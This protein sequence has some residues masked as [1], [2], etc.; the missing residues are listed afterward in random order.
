MW[1]TGTVSRMRDL[2]SAF[3]SLFLPLVAAAVLVR[4]T[5]LFS[6]AAAQVAMLLG[7]MSMLYG[8][9]NALRHHRVGG[10]L[11]SITA[12]QSGTL[13]LN[14]VLLPTQG[15]AWLFY[16]LGCYGLNLACLW[17]GAVNARQE[18]GAP[19][20]VNAIQGLGRRRPW[21]A[22]VLTL[23]LLDVAG[24][25]PLAGGI[26]QLHVLGSILQGG[27]P[28]VLLALAIGANA[29]AWLLV[30]RWILAMWVS[31]T[32]ARQLMPTT[33]EAAVV[34]VAAVGGMLIAGIYAEAVLRWLDALIAGV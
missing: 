13:L 6:P 29:A 16:A 17:A 12:A 20:E 32:S 19:L 26:H 1:I 11:A 34:G 28:W 4:F 18:D 27:H 22:S 2:D 3:A 8:Y 15:W 21:L 31:P 5:Y 23:C 10:V 33:P 30:G 7:V 9:T 25:L 14:I 24:M